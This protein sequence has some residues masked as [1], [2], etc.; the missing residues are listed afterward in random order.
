[1]FYKETEF[2]EIANVGE[3]PE[4]WEVKKVDELFIV[5]SGTTPSTK[6]KSYWEQGTLNWITPTDLSKLNGII[7]IRTSERKITQKALKENN[8]T[9]LPKGSL[10]LS[11][12]APV[13]YVVV[14]KEPATFNQGC[15]GMAIKNSKETLP[16]FYFYYLLHKKWMLQNLSGG[17]TFKELSKDMLEKLRVVH[18]SLFEQR[19]IVEILLTIDR[20]IQKTIEVITQIKLL[21]KGLMKELLTKGIGHKEFKDSKIGSIPGTWSCESVGNVAKISRGA[22]YQYIQK[23]PSGGIHLIRINDFTVFQPII[24]AKTKDI[25]RYRVAENDI[26]FA[27]TGASA[28][29]TIFAEKKMDGYAHSYNVLRIHSTG[30]SPLFLF[31]SLNSEIAHIQMS[32][33]FT[34]AAQ[35]FLDMK[36]ISKLLLPCPPPFEQEKIVTRLSA[37]DKKLRLEI[38]QKQKYE[39]IKQGLMDLLLSGKVRV[40]VD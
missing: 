31:Y 24:V 37:V 17:S 32:Y 3:I 20:T 9:I 29:T 14:L 33:R 10:I 7:Y 16:E 38:K 28:G 18:M 19:K 2:K 39:K 36:A 4:T 27:G 25:L 34:G 23:S 6:K 11:T 8:L 40:K 22:G 12:R 5:K 13:G 15:K 35:H 26:L 21:K 1:M 30:I